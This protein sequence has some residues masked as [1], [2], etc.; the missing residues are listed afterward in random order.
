MRVYE[1]KKK[2]KNRI[3]LRILTKGN[4]HYSLISQ[5]YYLSMTF[6]FDLFIVSRISHTL[7]RFEHKFW[8]KFPISEIFFRI[9]VVIF[10]DVLLVFFPKASFNALTSLFITF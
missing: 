2:I 7:K 9:P 8:L 10:F 6:D 5:A 4:L 3:I 1:P